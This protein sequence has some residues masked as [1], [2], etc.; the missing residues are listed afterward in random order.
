VMWEGVPS[1]ALPWDGEPVMWEGKPSHAL[2]A[3]AGQL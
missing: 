2:P 3:G 1:Q